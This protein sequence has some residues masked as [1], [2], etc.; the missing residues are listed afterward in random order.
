M[1]FSRAPRL[2]WRS[3]KYLVYIAPWASA[4]GAFRFKAGRTC[5]WC[6]GSSYFR[7]LTR[8]GFRFLQVC[9]LTRGGFQVFSSFAPLCGPLQRDFRAFPA[10]MI[11]FPALPVKAG[12]PALCGAMLAL[13]SLC[14]VLQ[15][16]AQQVDSRRC[17]H[18]LSF[19]FF[20]RL[21]ATII[22]MNI[23]MSSMSSCVNSFFTSPYA[24]KS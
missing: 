4:W 15:T 22:S 13:Q 3:F 6:T 14:H 8:A 1:L 10:G 23:L 19:S 11:P 7:P 20:F 24:A 12:F 2:L 17:I 18:F 21:R 9:A 5:A 16:V